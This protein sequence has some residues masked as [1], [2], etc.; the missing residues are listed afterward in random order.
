MSLDFIYF[1]LEPLS[2]NVLYF[3]STLNQLISLHH[4]QHFLK[5][6]YLFIFVI[7]EHIISPSKM[8]MIQTITL[9][10]AMKRQG[11]CDKRDKT[12][13]RPHSP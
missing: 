9:N 1:L 3:F 5:K 13:I 4:L 2:L 12:K 11:R 6:I 8:H 7:Q 10:F